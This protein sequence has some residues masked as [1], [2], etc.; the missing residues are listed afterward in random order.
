VSEK[1]RLGF[2]D[3]VVGILPPAA[4]DPAGATHRD[5]GCSITP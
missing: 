2:R 1:L 3:V 5:R 4:S